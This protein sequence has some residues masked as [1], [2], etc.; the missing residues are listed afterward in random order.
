MGNF[1]VPPETWYE[2]PNALWSIGAK[3]DFKDMTAWCL[4]VFEVNGQ[5]GREIIVKDVALDEHRRHYLDRCNQPLQSRELLA[6]LWQ[7]TALRCY[8]QYGA[9]YMRF[10]ERS[11]SSRRKMVLSALRQIK[12][13]IVDGQ[14]KP[15]MLS[16]DKYL[17]WYHMFACESHRQMMVT[18]L[19][20]LG[21]EIEDVRTKSS[22]KLADEMMPWSVGLVPS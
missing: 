22:H 4:K 10:L 8:H 15:L 17:L 7:E 18:A 16:E 6:S 1:A 19:G 2:I 11:A 3:I 14:P 20:F 21:G 5:A 12:R 13:A 9:R